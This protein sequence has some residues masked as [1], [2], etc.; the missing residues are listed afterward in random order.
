MTDFEAMPIGTKERLRE[1]EEKVKPLENIKMSRMEMI[2]GKLELDLIP[3]EELFLI[4]ASSF[5]NIV[6]DADN[7]VECEILSQDIPEKISVRVQKHDKMTPHQA[8]KLAEEKVKEL[9]RKLE[10]ARGTVRF[11]AETDNWACAEIR[12]IRETIIGDSEIVSLNNPYLS[13]CG[14]KRA[15]QC[16]KEIE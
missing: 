3:P 9:E 11:Y 10:V 15:R 4:F 12:R 1:L 8:R 14:G 16:L 5:W 13:H 6:K 2:D 7:Y